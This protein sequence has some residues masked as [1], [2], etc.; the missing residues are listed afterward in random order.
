LLLVM[1][2]WLSTLSMLLGR[3]AAS[4]VQSWRSNSWLCREVNA[5][6][7]M[8]FG[9]KLSTACW[10]SA[11]GRMIRHCDLLG[12]PGCSCKHSSLTSTAVTLSYFMVTRMKPC[13]QV[14]NQP[15][16]THTCCCYC[17]LSEAHFL[18]HASGRFYA[19][20]YRACFPCRCS[21]VVRT[22][23]RWIE[24]SN[25]EAKQA[26]GCG[27]CSAVRTGS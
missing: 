26:T 15:L 2:P 23:S 19:V 4:K 27:R 6:L 9:G 11:W 10:S 8:Q 24:R 18:V 25:R 20:L 1:I 3:H 12:Q 21:S 5:A 13:Y 22:N 14:A 16:L 17:C 7:C